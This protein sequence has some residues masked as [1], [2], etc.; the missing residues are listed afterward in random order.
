MQFTKVNGSNTLLT[1]CTNGTDRDAA[2]SLQMKWYPF[3]CIRH[4]GSLNMQNSSTI[5]AQLKLFTIETNITIEH[6]PSINGTQ[7][8]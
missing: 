6:Y 2:V 5:R 8:E 4:E 3:V 1:T 7:T